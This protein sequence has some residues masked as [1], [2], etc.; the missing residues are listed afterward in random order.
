MSKQQEMN[1]Y[2]QVSHPVTINTYLQNNMCKI[3]HFKVLNM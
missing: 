2:L 3:N 1:K